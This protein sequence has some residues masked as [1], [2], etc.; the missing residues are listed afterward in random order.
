VS[1]NPQES[2]S[3]RGEDEGQRER[4]FSGEHNYFAEVSLTWTVSIWIRRF[5]FFC[6]YVL[7]VN[8][9]YYRTGNGKWKKS[10]LI[11]YDPGSQCD[12][13]ALGRWLG[14]FSLQILLDPPLPKNSRI[15]SGALVGS[16]W[17]CTQV[18]LYVE[19]VTHQCTL[20]AESFAEAAALCGQ[21]DP[22]G[23][24]WISRTGNLGFRRPNSWRYVIIMIN[25][26][27]YV[28]IILYTFLSVL[29][30]FNATKGIKGCCHWDFISN[31]VFR[32]WILA[33][34]S[35]ID[36]QILT[37]IRSSFWPLPV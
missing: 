4:S 15:L 24:A 17:I 1:E 37:K 28:A 20:A 23:S 11:M 13:S 6:W 31:A 18:A 9:T 7:S 16:C 12:T 26:D 14:M 35:R 29:F 3:L 8:F 33:F 10:S 5:L 2:Q 36:P 19:A 30:P 22:V 32:E 27:N 21:W 25:Y 34:V